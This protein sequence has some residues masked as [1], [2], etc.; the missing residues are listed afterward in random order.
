MSSNHIT[1][2]DTFGIVD[3]KTGKLYPDLLTYSVKRDTFSQLRLFTRT[4]NNYDEG[5]TSNGYKVYSLHMD[6]KLKRALKLLP[7]PKDTIEVIISLQNR[8]TGR[9]ALARIYQKQQELFPI[10]ELPT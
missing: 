8:T 6:A 5:T 4:Y 3:S 2:R 7:R 10:Q 9:I 1:V